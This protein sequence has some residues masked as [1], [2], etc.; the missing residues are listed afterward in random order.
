MPAEEEE[1]LDSCALDEAGLSWALCPCS[2]PGSYSTSLRLCFLTHSGLA[3]APA[4]RVAEKS[5]RHSKHS[6]KWG[7]WPLAI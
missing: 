1:G 6:R 3:I 2:V 4:P 5:E 7:P